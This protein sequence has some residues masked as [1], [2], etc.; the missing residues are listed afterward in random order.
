[1]SW[2]NTNIYPSVEPVIVESAPATPVA[3]ESAEDK[4]KKPTKD[5]K[6]KPKADDE[7][8]SDEENDDDD[9]GEDDTDDD[10]NN[11]ARSNIK[12]C[13]L[14]LQFPSHDFKKFNF[15]S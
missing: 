7:E 14:H 6:N 9:D 3:S 12:V 5:R 15:F 2:S 13:L 11:K 4:E 1:M 8:E 10:D